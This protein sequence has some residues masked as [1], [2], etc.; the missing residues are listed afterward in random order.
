MRG[1]TASKSRE[2]QIGRIIEA[3]RNAMAYREAELKFYVPKSTV[4]DRL[5]ETRADPGRPK[6]KAFS[7]SEEQL[8]VSFILR[9]IDRAAP[10]HR[11][12]LQ[13]TVQIVADSMPKERR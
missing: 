8:I 9:C 6:R 3:V 10:L 7:D 2:R 12:H 1:S 11:H 5:Y 4:G 13:E